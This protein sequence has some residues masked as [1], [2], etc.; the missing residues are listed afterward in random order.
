MYVVFNVMFGVLVG[1]CGLLGS[2]VVVRCLLVVV[3]VR[4]CSVVAVV[5]CLLSFAGCW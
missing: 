3:C 5:C 4:C 2:C 1:V